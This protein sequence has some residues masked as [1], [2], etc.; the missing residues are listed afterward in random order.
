MS[1]AN[2]WKKAML[3]GLLVIVIPLLAV[4]ARP[5]PNQLL[6]GPPAAEATLDEALYRSNQYT[7][8]DDETPVANHL[9]IPSTFSLVGENAKLELYAENPN[10]AIR[11]LAKESGYIYGSS[12]AKSGEDIPNFNTRWEGIINSA[13]VIEYYT[14]NPSTGAYIITE[15]SF[16]MS[17]ATTL[18]YQLIDNGYELVVNYGISGISLTIRVYLDDDYLRVEVPASEISEGTA[19][20]L[21][22][23]KV[24]PFLGAVYGDSIPGYVFV[25]DGSGAL[26]RYKEIGAVSDIYEFPY[27]GVDAGITRTE[28]VDTNFNYPVSG[29]IL[30]IR[31]H[32][33]AQIVEDGDAFATLVVSPAKNN[34]RYY[35]TYNNF[36]YRRLYRTPTSRAAAASGTGQQVVE[37]TRNSC[38]IALVYAFLDGPA[39]D[40]VGMANAYQDYLVGSGKL[41][42]MAPRAEIP[43]LIELVGGDLTKGFIF[44]ALQVMTTYAEAEAMLAELKSFLPAITAVYKGYGRGGYSGKGSADVSVEAKLGT[45]AEL[46]ALLETY[47][48]ATDALYLYGDFQTVAESGSYNS[49]RD[50]SQ[51]IDS[52]IHSFSGLQKTYYYL[53]PRTSVNLIARAETAIGAMGAGG[54]AIGSLGYRLFSDYLDKSAPLDRAQAAALYRE[55]LDAAA[56]SLA[57]YRPNAY[58]LSSA[59][60]YLSAP[61][62]NSGYLIYTDTV[63]FVAI[64]LAGVMEAYGPYANFYANQ[65]RELLTLVDHGLLPAFIISAKPAYLLADTELGKLY[66]SDFAIW[67]GRIQ[68]IYELVAPALSAFYG[69]RVT[70]REALAHGVVRTTYANGVQVIV[71][72]TNKP[73]AAGAVSVGAL[74]FEVVMPSG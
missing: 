34:L 32:G 24:F 41:T 73:Y 61:T 51:R 28:A 21:R 19:Y 35:Y 13:A 14:Y 69:E 38:N 4:I 48:T 47:N 36:I 31:Q 59:D 40:Y 72:H 64:L 16:Y 53:N 67:E 43:A 9:D 5:L 29:M 26:I 62:T 27:Y 22:S 25:P 65:T 52:S 1:L 6:D 58:L 46:E 11:V 12:F 10:G 8:L 44:D 33:F 37:A 39:A 74:A 54:L 15:E 66:S 57:I 56:V 71:N 45:R 60:K 3:G 70:A 49:Y 63:P 7:Q 2:V 23:V 20:P 50:L 18:A 55:T 17:P 30:G 42:P 68:T